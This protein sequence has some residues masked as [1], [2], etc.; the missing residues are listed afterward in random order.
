MKGKLITAHI[1]PETMHIAKQTK[2]ILY[3]AF[4]QKEMPLHNSQIRL[5]TK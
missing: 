3:S 5:Y 1:T 2:I 4:V